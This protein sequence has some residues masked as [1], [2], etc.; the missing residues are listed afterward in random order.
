MEPVT[1]WTQQIPRPLPVA[2]LHPKPGKIGGCSQLQEPGSLPLSGG[3]SQLHVY[4]HLISGRSLGPERRGLLAIQFGQHV[5]LPISF[6]VLA[7]G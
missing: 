3:D 4:V 5:L 1:H 2:T 6:A 7:R